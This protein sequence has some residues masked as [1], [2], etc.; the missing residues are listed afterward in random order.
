MARAGLNRWSPLATTTLVLAA[1]APDIDVLS[2]FG[3]PLAAFKHHRGFTHS[4]LGVPL[5]SA[6]VVL[7]MYAAS[8]LW[9]PVTKRKAAAP[10]WGVLWGLACLAGLSH[11][12]LD[13]TTSYGVRPLDPF[14]WRWYSWDIV[15][16]V[17]PVLWLILGGGLLLPSLFALINEEVRSRRERL[18]RGR[19]GAL[20]ALAAVALFWGFR[21]YEHR[22]AIAAMQSLT[23]RGE[24]PLR[25]SA[26]PYAVNPFRWHGVVETVRAYHSLIVDSRTPE[27]DP[28]G[29]AKIRYKP[30]ESPELLAAKQSPAGRVFLGWARY[31]I[32]E[33]EPQ[34]RP[35][36]YLVHFYDL[37]YT[38]PERTRG[39]SLSAW[40]LLGSQL[41]VMGQ[42]FG[43]RP[44]F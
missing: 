20:V 43:R 41:Q 5:V 31:P 33:S 9:R 27:V 42:T 7:V 8:R 30:P 11:I 37:R 40:V 21:D 34:E 12:L 29:R 28:D 10:R 4:F 38:D 24:D 18:P 3:G 23:Y 36:G 17:D 19:A 39:S 15:S 44:E 32:I 13:F 22:H 2:W 14:S 6:S 25:V 1:E 26:F 16:I 35:P